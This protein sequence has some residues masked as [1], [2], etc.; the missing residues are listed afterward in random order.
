MP[1][2][3]AAW[4]TSPSPISSAKSDQECGRSKN[5]PYPVGPEQQVIGSQGDRKHEERQPHLP[6][7]GSRKDEP[8][9]VHVEGG[10]PAVAHGS[11]RCHQ[12][13]EHAEHDQ[14]RAQPGHRARPSIESGGESLGCD[15]ALKSRD[16]EKLQRRGISDEARGF[17]QQVQL[18]P[19][20]ATVKL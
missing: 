20:L 9:R 3:M 18:D 4:P 10:G 14:D 8:K 12:P 13:A 5:E 17:E 11:G 19:Y 6:E 2:A 7:A 15:E 16:A 1:L